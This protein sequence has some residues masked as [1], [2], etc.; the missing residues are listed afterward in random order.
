[1]VRTVRAHA[2]EDTHMSLAACQLADANAAATRHGAAVGAYVGMQTAMVSAMMAFAM[3]RGAGLVEQGDMT[4]GALA[5]FG[6]TAQRAMSAMGVLAGLG[7]EVSRAGEAWERIRAAVE[8]VPLI[9]VRGGVIP[10]DADV[11]GR[12]ELRGVA[13]RYAPDSAEVLRGVDLAVGAGE[14]VALVG[15]SGGGKSTIAALLERF[16]D[17][18]AGAVLLDGRDVRELD[19]SWLRRQIAFVSQHPQLF[20]STIREAI[21]YGRPDA[22]DAEVA[23]AA[24]RANC[25]EF[26]DAFPDG[27]D[28]RVTE[29][30]AS[31]SGGQ[32]QRVAIAR[33]ILKNPRILVLD[34]ATSAL[35]AS[36][37]RLVQEAL[38]NLMRDRT[39]IVI[40]HRLSSVVNADAIAVIDRGMI[41]ERGRHDDLLRRGGKYAALVRDQLHADAT[42]AA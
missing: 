26:I 40:A 38:D 9:P 37:E 20:A 32:R 4:S 14:V 5:A 41:V 30:G 29:G 39:V 31:L 35:D 21:R 19:P 18:T 7:G 3:Y 34:E 28:T 24:R 17:P 2:S 12:L 23:D 13:F 11:R 33:A 6:L 10:R 22:T 15:R 8:R 16:Y 42:P 1:M 27:W 25:T 36:S